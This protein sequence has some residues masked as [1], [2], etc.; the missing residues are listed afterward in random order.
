[1]LQTEQKCF[2]S[3]FHNPRLFLICPGFLPNA[4]ALLLILPPGF[5]PSLPPD[6]RH[7][8]RQGW[9]FAQTTWGGRRQHPNG[10]GPPSEGSSSTDNRCH[11]SR[12]KY[13]RK[14]DCLKKGPEGSCEV[15]QGF[16]KKWR[17]HTK[18]WISTANQ[19]L[20]ALGTLDT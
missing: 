9:V 3:T 6:I 11:P 1:M 13:S 20:T 5:S 16:L 2:P 12:L 10:G 15:S 18:E 4:S 8:R 14:E 17:L 7:P 19:L